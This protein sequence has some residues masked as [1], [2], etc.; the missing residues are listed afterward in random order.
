M[1]ISRRQ[2]LSLIAFSSVAAS[3]KLAMAAEQITPEQFG[4][5]GD[6][7][8]ADGP[9]L[10]AMVEHINSLGGDARVY[11]RCAGNYSLADA[12]RRPV[13]PSLTELSPGMTFGLPAITRSNVT[14]DAQGAR[15]RVPETFAFTRIKRGGSTDDRFF[16]MWEFWGD[17]IEFLGG[18]IDGNLGARPV[19]RGPRP[20]GFGGKDFGVI[21]R[22]AN[23]LLDGVDVRAFGTDDVLVT[24][25]GRA[26]NCRFSYARRNGLSVVATQP[27]SAQQPVIIEN[28][29]FSHNGDWPD[30]VYNNPAAGMVV[31]AGRDAK[32]ASVIIRDNYFSD[33]KMKDLQLAKASV[34]CVVTGN[35][36]SHDLNLR[37][38][39]MGGHL[40]EGNDFLGDARIKITSTDPNAKPVRIRGNRQ[41]GT[42]VDD[43]FVR[44]VRSSVKGA[45]FE[46]DVLD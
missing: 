2:V 38:M 15:F 5:R 41:N 8:A 23:W 44:H 20:I 28:C 17:N 3:C 4:A 24:N 36:F 11:V 26:S 18:L 19:R 33:N 39:Q 22:G 7:R 25:W 9:A 16:V 34:D 21:V 40:I 35:T 43:R 42:P 30:D 45:G 13:T 46:Q 1:T 31:E 37:P 29:E 6:G 27:I 14:I 10:A 32:S 12:P